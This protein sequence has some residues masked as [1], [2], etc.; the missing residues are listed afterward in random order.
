M[1]RPRFPRLKDGD[2]LE[3]RHINII[4][5][6][7]ERWN[8]TI[9]A[10]GV[11]FENRVSGP[12]ISGA[13]GGIGGVGDGL[14]LLVMA[15]GSTSTIAA[16]GTATVTLYDGDT[17]GTNTAEVTNP[18]PDTVPDGPKRLFLGRIV[19]IPGLSILFWSCI[20]DA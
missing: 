13:G 2:Q 5:A 20:D 17:L 12:V 10:G 1:A 16:G 4:Y 18:G 8:K 14:A 9:G 7:L 11:V 19:G 6:E 3:P 15:I